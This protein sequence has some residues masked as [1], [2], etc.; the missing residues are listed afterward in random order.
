VREIDATTGRVTVDVPVGDARVFTVEAFP[1]GS[2]IRNFIGT[3]GPINIPS[4]GANVTVNM[5]AIELVSIEVTPANSSTALGL[6]QQF[7]AT[8][9][10]SDGSTQNLTTTVLWASSAPSFATISNAPGT[11][12]LATSVASGD[13]ITIS[14]TSDGISG[15]TQLTVTNAILTSIEV[16]PADSLLPLGLT[17]QFTAIGI[18]SD[19]S[20]RDLTTT[21]LWESSDETIATISNAPGT[22]GLATSVA[23]G[24]PISIQATKVPEGIS[25]QTQLTVTTED[26]VVTDGIGCTGTT[27]SIFRVSPDGSSINTIASMAN[28]R[29]LG[30]ALNTFGNFVV[31][32]LCVGPRILTVTPSGNISTF[33]TGAPLQN[34]VAIIVDLLGNIIVGDNLTDSLFRITPDGQ[35]I[36]EFVSLP[37]PSPQTL[38]DIEIAMDSLGDF[39]VATD[40]IGGQIGR[41][42]ILRVTQDGFVSTIFDGT[43]IQS[44]GGLDIDSSGNF[45]VADFR[46]QAIFRVTPSGNVTTIVSGPSLGTNMTGLAVDSSGNYIVTVNFDNTVLRITPTGIVSTLVSG[47]PLTFPNAVTTLPVTPDD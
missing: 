18:F 22:Q 31:T 10:F 4:T 29:F 33:F 16:T 8:G 17:Q 42:M 5:R 15:E 37:F 6:T 39:I 13:S 34:P 3:S 46:Q 23:L 14:A 41:S 11:Q 38:Q 40:T 35:F 28:S 2:S 27:S 44:I 9:I 19:E 24:G 12:G 7:T 36:E 1:L 30:I 45:I 47:N 20:R 26:L 32:E 21:V 43:S 25:G